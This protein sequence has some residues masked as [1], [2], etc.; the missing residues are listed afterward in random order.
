[1]AAKAAGPKGHGQN[2]DGPRRPS[3]VDAI[4]T[5]YVPLIASRSTFIF[6]TK[7]GPG[8]SDPAG[9]HPPTVEETEMENRKKTQTE[10]QALQQDGRGGG[11]DR[12]AFL[13]RGSAVLAGAAVAA[14]VVTGETTPEEA[15]RQ[16]LRDARSSRKSKSYDPNDLQAGWFSV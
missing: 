12:R 1:M 14:P 3:V 8:G 6:N 4:S 9:D 16:A 2:P 11:L 10:R 7:T 13:L 5:F 15:R